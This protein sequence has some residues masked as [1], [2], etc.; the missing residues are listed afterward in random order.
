MPWAVFEVKDISVDS[1]KAVI[2][3]NNSVDILL[4]RCGAN[5]IPPPNELNKFLRINNVALE[6]MTTDAACRTFNVLLA[7]DRRVAAGLMGVE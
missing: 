2:I 4:V 3:E 5:A 1:L 6:W 7:E